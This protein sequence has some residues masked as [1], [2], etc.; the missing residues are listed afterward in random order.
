[1]NSSLNS[2]DFCRRIVVYCK[3]KWWSYDKKN[4]EDYKNVGQQDDNKSTKRKMF[5][6]P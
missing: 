6:L 3:K 5:I 2:E 4:V 1:M